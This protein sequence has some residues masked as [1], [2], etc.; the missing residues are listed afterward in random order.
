MHSLICNAFE[1]IKTAQG[2]G[3]RTDKRNARLNANAPIVVRERHPKSRGKPPRQGYVRDARMREVWL[4]RAIVRDDA[5]S[6]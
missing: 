4:W 1:L 5:N 2:R 3:R 6:R